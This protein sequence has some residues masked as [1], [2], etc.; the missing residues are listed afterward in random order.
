MLTKAREEAL[1]Y[2]APK[3][4]MESSQESNRGQMDC[5]MSLLRM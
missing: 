3:S 2:G 1:G 4:A 5:S